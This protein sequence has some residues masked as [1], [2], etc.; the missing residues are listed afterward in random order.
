MSELY[1]T[2]F[3]NQY[4]NLN[5]KERNLFS[6]LVNKLLSLNFILCLR[7]ADIEDYYFITGHL[8]LFQAYFYLMNNEL[9]YDTTNKVVVLQNKEN[10]NRLNLK[11]NES[12]V[13]L[14]LRLLYDELMRDIS[15]NDKIIIRLEDIHDKLFASGL[16]ERRICKTE[17]RQILALFK[18][19]NLVDILDYDFN[20]DLSRICL[21][22][23]ILYAVSTEDINKVCNKLNSYNR[24]CET[25]EETCED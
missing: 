11:L 3:C 8:T 7:E 19:Y 23:S 24:G 5:E 13:L 14:I 12:I 4:L 2:D 21:Y 22:P 6:K 18:R 15:L 1:V 25:N 17:L 9:I 10:Y 16:K 20:D